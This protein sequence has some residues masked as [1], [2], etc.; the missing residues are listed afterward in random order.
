MKI[1]KEFL[2]GFIIIALGFLGIA[3]GWFMATI[4]LL[5]VI[6][7]QITLVIAV[8][9]VSWLVGRWY[10]EEDNPKKRRRIK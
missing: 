2:V 1:L 6:F 9:M 5:S 8:V 7:L 10:L 3:F 4:V